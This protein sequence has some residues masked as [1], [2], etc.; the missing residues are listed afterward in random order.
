[1]SYIPKYI[2]K[3]MFPDDSFKKVENG[4]EVT[5]INVLSPLSVD[6][7]PDDVMNYLEASIDGTPVA[8][9]DK[10]K[11]EITTGGNT[12]TIANAKEF[13]GVVIPVGGTIKVFIPCDLEE[14][15]EHEFGIN[16]KT[17]HPFLLNVK[18]TIMS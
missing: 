13:A 17:E 3:R 18:R 2:L 8:D 15:S 12:Y 6:E 1:M 7:V 9:E 5:M 14:G 10:E 11:I 16:I 4:I